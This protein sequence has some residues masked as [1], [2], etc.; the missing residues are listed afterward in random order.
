TN[1]DGWRSSI[2]FRAHSNRKLTQAREHPATAAAPN[3][4]PR[5]KG[6]KECQRLWANDANKRDSSAVSE[7]PLVDRH[8]P[9]FVLTALPPHPA[10][11]TPKSQRHRFA[12]RRNAPSEALWPGPD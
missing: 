10:A 3:P 9:S 7:P 5:P 8:Q 1:A 2:K 11:P 4:R 6:K 12:L